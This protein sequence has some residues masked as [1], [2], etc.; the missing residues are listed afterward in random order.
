[1]PSKP[2]NDSPAFL[3]TYGLRVNTRAKDLAIQINAYLHMKMIDNSPAC[4]DDLADAQMA[5]DVATCVLA[6]E[7]LL[8][9]YKD[10]ATAMNINY[11]PA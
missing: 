7:T 10:T 5:E 3:N 1:M 6:L 8:Q 11:H 9:T 4:P 2:P